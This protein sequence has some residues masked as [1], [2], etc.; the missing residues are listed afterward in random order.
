MNIKNITAKDILLKKVREALLEKTANPFPAFEPSA[1][2]PAEEEEM[3]FVFARELTAVGGEFVY[4]EDE[5][6]L[7]EQLI[8]LTEERKLKHIYAW[9]KGI[10]NI[11]GRYGFPLR[12]SED[13]FEQADAGITSCEVLIARNGSVMISS[14]N[15]SGRRL[16]AYAPVHIVI[17][18]ASQM[19]MDLKDALAFVE[20]RYQG[21]IPSLLSTITGPSRTADIE[22][23]LVM[24]AHGPKSLYVFLLEDRF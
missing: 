13:E 20:R 19:V 2:Y 8:A 24:G 18:K 14:G 5:L 21:H 22:K 11:L 3:D 17:A 4:C 23:E 6:S 16:S 1:L 12:M 10:Q 7:I 15:A 9:E